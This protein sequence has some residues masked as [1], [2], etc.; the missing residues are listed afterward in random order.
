MGRAV[1]GRRATVLL[2][3]A[4]LLVLTSA[5]TGF[6]TAAFTSSSSSTATVRAA[7]D[8]TPPTVAVTAPGATLR[9]T[10]TVSA[11]ATDDQTGIAS[12]TLQH[13]RVGTTSWTTLCND[14]TSPYSCSWNT[15][16]VS[17]GSYDLRARATDGAGNV[18]VS[19]SVRTAV[20]NG[21]T[22]V[23]ADPGHALRGTVPLTATL[24]N[25]L[26]GHPLRIEYAPT[27]TTTW[28]TICSGHGTTLTCSWNTAA[29]PDGTYD[30]RAVGSI[31]LGTVT[32]DVARAVVVDNTVPTVTMTNPGSPLSGTRTFAATAADNGSGVGQVTVQHSRAGGPWTTLCVLAT[33]PWS[34]SY[35][36]RSLADGLYSFRAVAT[37]RAGNSATSVAVTNRTVNNQVAGPAGQRDASATNERRAA[38]NPDTQQAPPASTEE[39]TEPAELTEPD[40]PT[41]PVEESTPDPTPVCA[42]DVQTVDGG[43]EVGRIEEGDALVLTYTGQIDTRSVMT[44]WTGDSAP[45]T[46]RLRDGS[47][48][49][50]GEHDTLDVLSESGPVSLGSVWLDQDQVAPGASVELRATMTARTDT[51]DGVPRSTVTVVLAEPV[52]DVLELLSAQGAATLVWSPAPSVTGLDGLPCSPDPVSEGGPSDLDF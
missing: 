3:L 43:G 26:L 46:V 41:E 44:G 14:T 22:L 39:A 31:L 16:A 1:P 38:G 29:L 52:T 5:V 10:V 33:A 48:L 7:M 15:N 11:Q 49:G 6:S 51:V 8:W 35:D 40:V 50:P 24:H 42:A 18:A 37:D 36:T 20:T 19:A 28:R 25:T 45:V 32:S 9:N 34:C 17:D 2:L 30:L 47:L 21:T 12:V 23:L 27:G 4:A 13:Q